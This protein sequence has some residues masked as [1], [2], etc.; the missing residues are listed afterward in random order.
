MIGRLGTEE[1]QILTINVH[2]V[3]PTLIGIARFATGSREIDPSLL[4]I[5][6]QNIAHRPIACGNR[7]D[8]FR[9]RK[10]VQVEVAE[11]ATFGIRS[12]EHTYEL[13]SLMR[14]SYAVFCLKKNKTHKQTQTLIS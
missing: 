6:F 10:I 5:D 3:H 8:H 11:A 12:E 13:Q 7:V 4:F 2:A 14:I 1:R 9:G